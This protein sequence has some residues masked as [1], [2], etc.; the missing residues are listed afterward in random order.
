MNRCTIHKYFKGNLIALRHC[1]RVDAVAGTLVSHL[2]SSFRLPRSYRRSTL[3]TPANTRPLKPWSAI[4]MSSTAVCVYMC[5]DQPIIQT[6]KHTHQAHLMDKMQRCLAVS[7]TSQLVCFDECLCE[8][9]WYSKARIKRHS[10]HGHRV[11]SWFHTIM[12]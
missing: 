4:T 5:V 12:Q 6:H 8:F 2:R 10:T 11:G 7:I 9:L 1:K 3:P